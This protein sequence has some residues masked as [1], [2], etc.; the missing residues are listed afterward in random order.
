MEFPR[1]E[2]W[3]GLPFPSPGNLSNPRI[4][5][6]SPALAWRFFT[7]EPAGK[8]NICQYPQLEVIRKMLGVPLF[9]PDSWVG[10]PVLSWPDPHG[11]RGQRRAWLQSLQSRVL[12]VHGG[13]NSKL[14]KTYRYLQ[15][16]QMV[17]QTK[18]AWNAGD[19]GSIPGLGRSPAK[20]IATTHSSLLAW[21]IP[22]TEE[23][24]GLQSVGSQR[25]GYDWATNR[26]AI[27]IQIKTIMRV[28]I[29]LHMTQVQCI[30]TAH[31]TQYQKTSNQIKHGQKT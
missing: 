8:P 12:E 2:Y 4:E 21:R 19:L 20:G 22:W 17:A 27:S 25:I 26:H 18:S 13:S 29:S 1:Q 23:P 24:G 5:P 14:N 15:A 3:S 28:N 6:R 10:T 16:S 31:T 11:V 9:C 30:Q 7:T